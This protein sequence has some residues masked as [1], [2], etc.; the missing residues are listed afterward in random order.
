[1]S[2]RIVLVVSVVV[3]SGLLL[4]CGNSGTSD[5]GRDAGPSDLGHSEADA[6]TIMDGGADLGPLTGCD[7]RAAPSTCDPGQDCTFREHIAHE[8]IGDFQCRFPGPVAEGSPC[9]TSNYSDGDALYATD[10]CAAG[11]LC[12][13]VGG[14]M[15]ECA[16]FCTRDADCD[17]ARRCYAFGPTASGIGMVGV[18][19]TPQSCD[20]LTNTG[21]TSPLGCKLLE[22]V[23]GTF[24][25]GCNR[26]SVLDVD[27]GC[28]G[29]RCAAGL[30]CLPPLS[31]SGGVDH[32]SED[33]RCRRA[34]NPTATPPGCPT[35]STCTAV[36]ASG[37]AHYGFCRFDDPMPVG[38]VRPARVVVPTSYDGTTPLPL[39]VALHYF[40]TDAS[41]FD[42]LM[43]FSHQAQVDGFFLV[44]PNGTRDAHDVRFWNGTPACCDVDGAMPDDSAY[45]QGLID[46][47]KTRYHVDSTR[48]YVFGY[49]DGGFMA[50]RMA[51]DH[52]DSITAIAS[53]SGATFDLETDCHASQPVSVLESHGD[54][55]TVIV[56]LGGSAVI[57]PLTA[58]YPGARDTVERWATRAGCNLT[59]AVDGTPFDVD[60]SV[61]GAETTPRDYAIGCAGGV[62][63]ALWTEHGSD[64]FPPLAPDYTARVYAW[65]SAHH[66]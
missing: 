46:E 16:R 36:V 34:C 42:G 13:A 31:P 32:G 51:C 5:A 48:V 43:R 7:P 49:F 23:D 26:T 38:G 28:A 6:D 14:A 58:R 66:R 17:G 8:A 39:V 37:S 57:D 47:M 24:A 60:T 33:L 64:V 35:G 45:L 21:C 25:P 41:Y 10:D 56:Y 55:D 1:M 3:V 12:A 30:T 11:L 44:L 2:R 54:A 65:L 61:T 15:A 18:C 20:P 59:M 53:L 62:N 40:S 27:E 29:I 22:L 63:T 52:A 19:R 50:Y 4:A 9:T